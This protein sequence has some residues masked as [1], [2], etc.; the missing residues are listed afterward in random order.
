MA[1]W[2]LA[3]SF[4]LGV[5]GWVAILRKL[6]SFISSIVKTLAV[7]VGVWLSLAPAQAVTYANASIPLAWIDPISGGH[8]RVGYNTG[9]YFFS[10]TGGCG[11]SGTT[12]DDTLSNEITLGFAFWFGGV[13]YNSVRISTN[14]RL[15]FNN[16]TCG[17]GT[18]NIGPPQT[19]PYV[20]PDA[21][22]SRTMKIFGADLDPTDLV[23][24]S[25]YPSP[26]ARTNCKR[27]GS[28]ANSCGIY[29]ATLGAAPYRKF[30][31]TWYNVPEWI[32]FSNTSGSF[33][34]Q[35]ILHENGEF[36]FQYLSL[37][38]GGTGQ[39]EVGWQ[40]DTQDYD[41]LQFP[42]GSEPDNNTAIKF[43]IPQPMAEYRMEQGSWPSGA[44]VLDT[45]GNARHASTF[46]AGA[47]GLPVPTPSGRVCRGA[48]IPSNSSAADISA[49]ATP[50]SMQTVGSQG[51]VTFW[52]R[53]V[54]NS[55]PRMLLDASGVSA[56][57][58][59]S[60]W[61]YAMKTASRQLKFVVYDNAG[62]RYEALT[63]ANT[64]S[65]TGNWDHIGVSWNFNAKAGTGQDRLLLWINGTLVTT[66]TFTTSQP[67]ATTIGTLYIGDNRS[68]LGVE[69]NSGNPSASG[70]R[71]TGNSAGSVIDEVRIYNF[72]GGK[73]LID[74]DR[75]QASGCLASYGVAH[76]GTGSTCQPTT[77][78]ISAYDAS[79][80]LL[81]MPNNTT[82]IQVSTSTG[83]GDWAIINGYGVLNNG[84]ADDGVATYLFNGE[85]Q[86]VLGLTHS[87][88]GVVN[89]NVT[90]GQLVESATRDPN[91]TVSLCSGIAGFNACDQIATV[92]R[93]VPPV[94]SDPG[95]VAYARLRTKLAGDGF[96][97]DLVALK[98]DG[99]IETS[100]AGRVNVDL[101]AN[102]NDGVAISA[103]NYC[104][105]SQTAII[106]VATN[107]PFGSLAVPPDAA[108]YAKT[109][110]T[111]N[112]LST[113]VTG[114]PGYQA[115]RDVRVRITC[116]ST[117]CP[118]SGMV[119][120]SSDNFAIRPKDVTVTPVAPL[121]VNNN[122]YAGAV[123]YS[124]I[125]GS[126]FSLQAITVP[127]YNGVLG[128]DRSGG[129]I[130]SCWGA[131]AGCPGP[132]PT[133]ALRN[134]AGTSVATFNTATVATGGTGSSVFQYHDAGTFRFE[135][136]SV[137]DQ[138]YTTVDQPNDCIQNSSTNIADA[139]GRVG[140]TLANQ[141]QV[142]PFGRFRPNNFLYVSGGV[143]QSQGGFSYFGRTNDFA[144]TYTLEARSLGNPT[145]AD[146]IVTT[147]YDAATPNLVASDGAAT[148]DL[149][150]SGR[151]AWVGGGG[152]WSNGQ[153]V[154]NS[155]NSLTRPAT[156]VGNGPYENL[157]FGVN[158]TESGLD[159]VTM[160]TPRN[161]KLGGPNCTVA[162]TH[163][164]I[165]PVAA[166]ARFGRLRLSNV[167]GSVS[168]L[169]MP[170]EAQYWGG[171]SWVK[172][173]LDNASLSSVV[174]SYDTAGW[175]LPALPTLAGGS[176]FLTINPASVGVRTVT[177]NL[178]A[179]PWLQGNW[180]GAAAY[181]QNPS[182]VAS[183]GV[184][185]T[186]QAQRVIHVREMF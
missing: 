71:G 94:T 177:A 29:I 42:N 152:A 22:L 120:C 57:N 131:S 168:P 145:A 92:L 46:N 35:A 95:N 55:T 163:K 14:G 180:N 59:S 110:V 102:S 115:Y 16:T 15:Q 63:A 178:A 97:F 107:V 79:G 27:S 87:L 160:T 175:T 51:T 80:N 58:G 171:R 30:V 54:D 149:L 113:V 88:A 157:F 72:E 141:A 98:G 11:T 129:L 37:N 61:F 60:R 39:A 122:S 100:F 40:I 68:S 124:Q 170:V 155:G 10:N 43:Y 93:C 148:T 64:L 32:N 186:S 17:A 184:Y 132:L 56:L 47:G 118:P 7:L 90:D 167:Y 112:M 140:C 24:S 21:G 77:I 25:N 20:Y 4:E 48:S 173:T 161:F 69:D 6:M 13:S 106:P 36:V 119:R 121:V 45:S 1:V 116:N 127:G 52:Y 23:D 139:Q 126:D 19:Y 70:A 138:A 84:T 78:T 65:T 125:A 38:H 26:A 151:V 114:N 182:A 8:T 181:D 67:L 123:G 73:G 85:Y 144:L 150:A 183:F 76:L 165:N 158:L 12:L 133:S 159:G 66:L 142:G 83:R 134:V 18:Q 28:G 143:T 44:S 172:N 108:G 89:I 82:T 146:A 91:L 34:M 41:V 33:T 96:A 174:L 62:V 103:A 3:F 154:F 86:V 53:H 111:A 156:P 5:S 179:M 164:Q 169:Q 104:P 147:R 137:S 185:G 74:R 50:F 105:V 2:P 130:T 136:S 31:V 99:T 162:C 101:V 176:A 153:Y 166:I 128:F 81:V 49:I 75:N 109:T 117:Y 135:P 9:T